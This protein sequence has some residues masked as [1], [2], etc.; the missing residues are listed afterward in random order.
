MLKD[1]ALALYVAMFAFFCVVDYY[2]LI[3]FL[4]LIYILYF[5]IYHECKPNLHILCGDNEDYVVSYIK[6]NSELYDDIFIIEVDEDADD[7]DDDESLE[8]TLDAD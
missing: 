4:P 2:T 1:V 6:I 5:L 8:D 3:I 7:D